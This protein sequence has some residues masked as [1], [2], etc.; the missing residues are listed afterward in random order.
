LPKLIIAKIARIEE[1]IT[2]AAILAIMTIL[3]MT[4]DRPEFRGFQDDA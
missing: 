3:A 1:R 2:I 4:E